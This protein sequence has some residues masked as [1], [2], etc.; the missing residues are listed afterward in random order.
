MALLPH[1]IRGRI[2]YSRFVS[3]RVSSI[4]L[5]AFA[6][7]FLVVFVVTQ[8]SFVL[9]GSVT[10]LSTSWAHWR[11][12]REYALRGGGGWEEADA[13]NDTSPPSSTTLEPFQ[14]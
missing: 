7:M 3:L 14:Q 5:V 11:L 13:A 12:A 1:A 2:E 4:E 10:C 6:A 8:S 9:G